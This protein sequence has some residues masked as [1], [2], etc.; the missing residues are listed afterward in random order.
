MQGKLNTVIIHFPDEF[1]NKINLLDY[2]LYGYLQGERCDKLNTLSINHFDS[3][4]LI[5]ESE[6]AKTKEKFIHGIGYRENQKT[7][8]IFKKS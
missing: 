5:H 8:L 3:I 7:I 2:H 4:E 6:N 1:R